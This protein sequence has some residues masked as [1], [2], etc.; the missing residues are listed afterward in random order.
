MEQQ[1]TPTSRKSISSTARPRTLPLDKSTGRVTPT[2]KSNNKTTGR[3][4]KDTPTETQSSNKLSEF[5]KKTSRL[6]T[7]NLNKVQVV[8][9]EPRRKSAGSNL[10]KSKSNSMDNLLLDEDQQDMTPQGR[11][12]KP[13]S[14]WCTSKLTS[15][16]SVPDLLNPD[17]DGKLPMGS[18]HDPN[19]SEMSKQD[20]NDNV[21]NEQKGLKSLRK[22][23]PHTG[24]RSDIS[25][26]SSSRS[27]SAGR[28]CGGMN[29]SSSIEEKKGVSRQTGTAAA[30]VKASRSKDR[31]LMPPPALPNVMKMK[32]ETRF[33]K[34]AQQPRRK[35][36][37][38]SELTFEE[39]KNILKGNSGILNGRTE[40][41]RKRSSSTSPTG[42]RAKFSAVELEL[43][44]SNIGEITDPTLLD[45]AA[46]I[47]MTA[48]TIKRKSAPVADAGSHLEASPRDLP[49]R[50]IPPERDATRAR[51]K[52]TKSA[53]ILKLKPQPLNDVNTDMYSVDDS[54]RD[55]GLSTQ[56]DDGCSSPSVKERI[57]KLNKHGNE[58]GRTHSP[59][60]NQQSS[61]NPILDSP[62]LTSTIQISFSSPSTR[63]MSPSVT[64]MIDNMSTSSGAS[65]HMMS[66][67]STTD[68]FQTISQTPE[69]HML[70]P[71][72]T[73][74]SSHMSPG[75][76]MSS[77]GTFL[78]SSTQSHSPPS[79]PPPSLD[80]EGFSRHMS[81]GNHSNASPP[82]V[83]DTGL[84]SDTDLETRYRIFCTHYKSLVSVH[85]RRNTNSSHN[86]THV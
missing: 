70:Q 19:V 81:P 69:N 82:S 86:T 49:E 62:R 55:S 38:T 65:P 60:R 61:E 15:F 72:R 68:K 44:S 20:I 45:T 13:R 71:T 8:S 7:P 28:L 80:F 48:A 23:T 76:V 51:S 1:Q 12:R 50:D 56:E 34:R 5:K 40:K 63:S 10:A 58:P 11:T 32:Q 3:T 43:T 74:S 18:S 33:M 73:V 36:T 25:L 27:V 30:N 79:G 46:E 75:T 41:D 31:D 77:P 22:K 84:G 35:T 16:T 66:A 57:A 26:K 37:G 67:V 59:Y 47:E 29:R 2:D 14:K 4:R 64:S 9:P 42:N 78:S 54:T 85:L 6:S 21:I 39:A 24:Q 17:D 53:K 52:S 83:A